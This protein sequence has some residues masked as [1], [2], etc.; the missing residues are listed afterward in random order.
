MGFTD[1]HIDENNFQCNFGGEY[2]QAHLLG[3][4]TALK[5][6]RVSFRSSA[7]AESLTFK[8]RMKLSALE[9]LMAFPDDPISEGDLLG[10]VAGRVKRFS[11]AECLDFVPMDT[12]FI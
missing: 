6:S 12:C 9:W 1:S 2:L 3:P 11:E 8:Q 10:G 7:M 4:F 5:G